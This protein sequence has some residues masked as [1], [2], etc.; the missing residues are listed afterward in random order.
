MRNILRS[1]SVNPCEYTLARVNQSADFKSSGLRNRP[2]PTEFVSLRP[3]VLRG[4][5]RPD[6]LRDETLSEILAATARRSPQQ[7]ALIW[8]ERV[9]SRSEER[10]VGKEC[11]SRWSPYH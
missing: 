10:R 5:A 7:P 9:V 4:P 6:L 3:A 2:E 1:G 11:R 8:G